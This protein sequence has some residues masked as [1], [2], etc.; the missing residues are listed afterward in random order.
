MATTLSI[1][2]AQALISNL[3]DEVWEAERPSKSPAFEQFMNV[4]TMDRGEH[5]DYRTAGFG[6]FVE[7]P[8]LVDVTYDQLEFGEALTVKPKEWST[9]FRISQNVVEDLADA[10]SNDGINISKLGSYADF[11]RRAKR[12]AT[13]TVDQ[14]CADLLLNGTSTSAEYVLR[15]AI[16]LFGT[17]V[18]LKNPTV[19]QSNLSTHASLAATTLQSMTTTLDLQLDDRGDYISDDGQNI[20]VVSGTNDFRIYEILKTSGQVDSANNNVN[21]LSHKS[22]KPVVDKYLNTAGAAYN[23]Y[24]LLRDGVHSLNWLWRIQPEFAREN[25]FDAVAM[26]FRGRFRGVRYAK[27]WRGS[28]G[29]NGS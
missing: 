22:Y 3:I 18:T 6:K 10:G 27:D 24:F 12:S 19:S 8:E 25:D 28:V 23:G 2:E 21:P 13:W 4:K 11:V 14:E 20:I 29:D 7:R 5:V 9:G 1:N 17:H 26:K 15:D 16:A